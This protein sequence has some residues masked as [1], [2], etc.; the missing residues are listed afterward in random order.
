MKTRERKQEDLNALTEQFK[1]SKSA[2]VLTFNR[3]TVEQDQEFR[4]ELRETGA[5]YRVVKNTLARRAVEGTPFEDAREHF[6]GVTSV[7]WTDTDPVDL[8]KVISKYV[9]EKAEIFEFKTG[10][11]DGKVVTIEE[12]KAIASLPSKEEL[13]SKL[14]F[15]LKAPAQRVATVLNAVPRDL[16]LVLKQIADG[17]GSVE[18]PA[19]EAK[20]EKKAEA[21]EATAEEAKADAPEAKAEEAKAEAAEESSEDKSEEAKAASSED[22]SGEA[23]AEAEGDAAEAEAEEKLA[24]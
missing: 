16:A 17:Q 9:K 18:A 13:V 3:L 12:V 4:N 10:I 1:T 22:E 14:L 23:K 2:I 24:E 15:L 11:V 6:K 8:S 19:A 20:E 5:T 21:A 7:A